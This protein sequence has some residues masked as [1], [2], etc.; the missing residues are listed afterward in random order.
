[1][2][3]RG[4]PWQLLHNY[5]H[6]NAHYIK[7]EKENKKKKREKKKNK[8]GLKSEKAIHNLTTVKLKEQSKVYY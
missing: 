6:Q 7:S 2:G 3:C 8:K 1:M 5:I 4:S